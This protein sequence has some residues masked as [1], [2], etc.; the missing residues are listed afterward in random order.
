MGLF[1]RIKK[2]MLKVV[3]WTDSSTDVMVYKFPLNDRYALMKGSQLVVRESQE[4]IFVNEGKIADIFPA[5]RYEL[6]TKNLPVLTKILSWKYA[7]ETPFTGDIYYINTKQFT[8]LKWGTQNPVM[9]RDKDFGMIRLRG[10]GV[11]SFRVSDSET[12]MREV[13]GTMRSYSTLDIQ[14]YLKKIIVSALTDSIAETEIPALD[15]ARSYDEIGKFTQKKLGEKFSEYGLELTNLVIEN[16]SLPEEVEKSMDTRTSMGV[17]GDKM[18]TF[19]QY[20]T[21]KAIGDAARNTSG[22]AGAGMGIGAGFGFGGLMAK[23]ISDSVNTVSDKKEETLTCSKCGAE[24]KKGAKFC[25]ECGQKMNATKTCAKC[26]AELK[27]NAKF[28]SECGEPC[29]D[30]KTCECGAVLDAKAK[31]CPECGKPV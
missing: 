31:F 29:V 19:T 30:K 3:E 4:A 1:S 2:Q 26:G 17:M 5:G 18:G 24:V 7:F 22:G 27:Q 16:L 23:T 14:D 8:G 20:Q 28:C 11:Y 9:M 13:F 12:F 6:D 21:A 25:P 15:L 10:Y